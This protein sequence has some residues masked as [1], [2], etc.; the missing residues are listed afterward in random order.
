MTNTVAPRTDLVAHLPQLCTSDVIHAYVHPLQAL[1]NRGQHGYSGNVQFWE[2]EG[3]PVAWDGT[4]VGV[5]ALTTIKPLPIY[6][7]GWTDGLQRVANS[8]ATLL[9]LLEQ[10]L[11]HPR[12]G[13]KPIKDIK[14]AVAKFLADPRVL[15]YEERFPLMAR[16]YRIKDS[17]TRALAQKIVEAM[18]WGS[19]P[20]GKPLEIQQAFEQAWPYIQPMLEAARQEALAKRREKDRARRAAQQ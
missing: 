1:R 18:S 13:S 19:T 5:K 6:Y 20:S 3:E 16:A 4:K 12:T 17:D 2:A 9:P 7:K 11:G 14:A 15:R 8:L 10:P